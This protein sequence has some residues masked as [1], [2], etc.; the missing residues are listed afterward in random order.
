MH[1]KFGNPFSQDER[2]TDV[3][4]ITYNTVLRH[5]RRRYAEMLFF[6]PSILL[7]LRYYIFQNIAKKEKTWCWYDGFCSTIY[8]IYNIL[9]LIRVASHSHKE[10]IERDNFI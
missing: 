10:N 1:G 2:Y 9:S 7:F 6:L 5:G 3:S 4:V 8:V